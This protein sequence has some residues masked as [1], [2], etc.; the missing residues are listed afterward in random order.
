V[1]IYLY[2]GDFLISG[3]NKD[4]IDSIELLLKNNFDIKNLSK[5][6][7]ILGMRITRTS[8]GIFIDQSHYIEIFSRKIY[9]YRL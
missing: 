4:I 9:F 1:I 6:N 7:M 2:I 8:H 5:A 3:S